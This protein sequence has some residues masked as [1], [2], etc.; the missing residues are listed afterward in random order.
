MSGG[1]YTIENGIVFFHAQMA[2]DGYHSWDTER[3]CENKFLDDLIGAVTMGGQ[4]LPNPA[5]IFLLVRHRFSP[6]SVL[7]KHENEVALK[8]F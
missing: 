4:R 5:K 7:P 8:E 1:S 3:R 6:Q 2:R